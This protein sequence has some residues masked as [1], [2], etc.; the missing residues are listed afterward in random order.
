MGDTKA[1]AQYLARETFGKWHWWCGRM[2]GV[3]WK[4]RGGV[5][6]QPRLNL[7]SWKE[8]P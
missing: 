7:P 6:Q 1:M 4:D 3:V 2:P 5:T 8:V